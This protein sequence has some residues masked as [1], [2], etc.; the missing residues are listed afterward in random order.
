MEISRSRN[1]HIRLPRSVTLQPMALP[2]RSLKPAIDLRLSVTTGFWPAMIFRASTASSKYFFSPVALPTP[3]LTTIFCN[4]GSDKRLVRPN[5]SARPGQN[6]LLDSAAGGG[7]WE[8]PWAPLLALAFFAL[9][10]L[11]LVRLGRLFALGGLLAL[12]LFLALGRLFGLG[13]LLGRGWFF[14]LGC[15]FALGR[16]L[17]LGWLFNLGWLF[18][19]GLVSAPLASLRPWLVF[20]LPA[21]LRPRAPGPW[22]ASGP[23]LPF[24]LGRLVGRCLRLRR[25][26]RFRIRDGRLVFRSWSSFPGGVPGEPPRAASLSFSLA[27]SWEER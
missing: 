15:F 21:A 23:G 1:S 11:A 27:W 18:S 13:F 14:D 8:W 5:C 26:G 3:M 6:F 20:R 19:L 12:G 22:A 9:A 2:S 24:L 17:D 7:A 10:L 16:L 4:R 25:D